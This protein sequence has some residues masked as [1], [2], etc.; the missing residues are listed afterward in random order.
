[1]GL[2]LPGDERVDVRGCRGPGGQSPHRSE[3]FRCPP[4]VLNDGADQFR[5]YEFLVD[6][7]DGECIDGLVGLDQFAPR[8]KIANPALPDPEGPDYRCRGSCCGGV[9]RHHYVNNDVD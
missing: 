1:M 6:R 4:V 5:F 8:P 9:R 2:A 7:E 3:P